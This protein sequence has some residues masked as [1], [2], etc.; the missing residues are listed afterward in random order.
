[1]AFVSFIFEQLF[2]LLAPELV[3]WFEGSVVGVVF[4]SETDLVKK[5]LSIKSKF[6]FGMIFPLFINPPP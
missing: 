1:M 2:I 5:V 4:P 3:V 6:V